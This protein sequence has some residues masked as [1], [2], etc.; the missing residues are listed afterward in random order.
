MMAMKKLYRTDHKCVTIPFK[1]GPYV[2]RRR[3]AAGVGAAGAANAA[4]IN[5]TPVPVAA[6]APAGAAPVI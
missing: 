3:P 2:P 6:V 4:P 5:I 1:V